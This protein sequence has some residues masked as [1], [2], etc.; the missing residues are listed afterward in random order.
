MALGLDLSAQPAPP[1]WPSLLELTPPPSARGVSAVVPAG[2]IARPALTFNGPLGPPPSPP[3]ILFGDTWPPCSPSAAMVTTDSRIPSGG[4]G[5]GTT[6][7]DVSGGGGRGGGDGG[8]GGGGVGVLLGGER[9]P[10]EVPRY[11]T[12][13]TAPPADWALPC[14]CP[15]MCGS[16]AMKGVDKAGP[17][18][19]ALVSMSP[20]CESP[21]SKPRRTKKLAERARMA[22]ALAALPPAGQGRLGAGVGSR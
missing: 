16:A 9:L 1:S 22:A 19:A 18:T 7:P 14:G 10:P 8:G 11:L 4:S 15:C 2:A 5:G 20:V 17:A 13:A 3:T 12:E 21:M 6:Q